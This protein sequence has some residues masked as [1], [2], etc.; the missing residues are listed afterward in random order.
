[1]ASV[2]VFPNVATH[3]KLPHLQP[4]DTH[5]D[6]APATASDTTQPSQD[7]LHS[8]LHQ[9]TIQD[10][11]QQQP[12]HLS[13]GQPRPMIQDA[14][15]STASQQQLPRLVE[16]DAKHILTVDTQPPPSS[17]SLSYQQ[18]KEMVQS[19]ASALS[20][21]PSPFSQARLPSS[22]VNESPYSA[23]PPSGLPSSSSSTSSASKQQHHHSHHPSAELLKTAIY[24]A[25][26]C[27]YHP[28]QHTHHPSSK[29]S[30]TAAAAL[31]SG[32]VTPLLGVSPRAS[33]RLLPQG[34]SGPITPLEL[35]SDES[36]ALAHA[37]GYFG[38]TPTANVSSSSSQAP[39]TPGGRQGAAT[40][41][42]ASGTS[43]TGAVS[44][45]H[46]EGHP[47]QHH[48]HHHHHQHRPHTSSH[49]HTASSLSSD[50]EDTIS[51]HAINSSSNDHGRRS[52]PISAVSSRRSSIMMTMKTDMP[53]NATEHPVL[54]TLQ[55]MT[56]HALPGYLD[57]DLGHDCVPLPPVSTQVVV[58]SSS[59]T[60]SFTVAE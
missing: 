8:S 49:L 60:S 45:G 54:N 40:G 4:K 43:G 5:K 2:I 32:E 35:S 44:G 37:G 51:T 12:L 55:T 20:T 58:A 57:H 52:Q 1:M 24:D 28:M 31:R 16:P 46:Q 13:Q 25:F 21:A 36:T 33:P 53:M 38:I 18:H 26:G 11:K 9:L 47:S 56:H 48:H 19:A 34:S 29:S 14:S 41:G 15:S 10:S 59:L 50:D 3:R 17:A 42:V 22:S 23:L 6:K 27:L 39:A 7:A 30:L